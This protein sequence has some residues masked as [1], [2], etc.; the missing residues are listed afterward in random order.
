MAHGVGELVQTH[1]L[2]SH[3]CALRWEDVPAATRERTKDLVLDHIGV[4]LFGATME[5]SRIVREVVGGEGGVAESTI[6]GG[7]RVPARVAALVNGVAAHG[8]ELDD[9]HDESLSHPGCV[10]I[11]AAFTLAEAHRI[12]GTRFLTAMI[13]GYEA[14][15]RIGSVVGNVLIQ[16]GFHPTAQAGVFGATAAAGLV[17]GLDLTKLTRAFGLASSMSSGSMKFTQDAEGTMIKRMHA[18]MPS[19]RGVLAAKLAASGF[20]GPRAAI[21][22]PYGFA[23]IFTG[24][25]NL[26]RM[27]D[28]LG[29]SFEIDSISIKLYP[30]CRMFHS[31]IEAIAECR[32][33]PGF[34]ADQ[35]VSVEAYGP[36]NMLDGHLEFRP[37]S[38]MAAQYS[39]PYTIA[40]AT[41]LDPADPDS[42]SVETMQRPDVLAVADKVKPNFSA[43]LEALFPKRVPARV[44]FEMK[45]GRKLGSTVLDSRS[46]PQKPIGRAEI[47]AKFRSMT[48]AILSAGHQ[49]ALIESVQMLDC[50]PDVEAVAALLRADASTKVLRVVGKA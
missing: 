1:T 36:R 40:A 50:A 37:A 39:L 16:R 25:D 14:M 46:T 18:G 34:Q 7:Q 47:V 38:T 10:I 6:Y 32:A 22:G 19:E 44:V 5:W 12:S 35:I 41:M 48:N 43:E 21:E 17:L 26:T 28:G 33:M 9:T 29:R 42:F 23:T 8:I 31:L 45:D 15:G 4:T 30:C 13:C 24:I 3:L 2:L 11:P 20:T 27:V 49:D